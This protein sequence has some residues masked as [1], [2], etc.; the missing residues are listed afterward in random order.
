MIY[1]TPDE[2]RT[3]ALRNI[4]FGIQLVQKQ[5]HLGGLDFNYSYVCG[6]IQMASCLT[7]ISFEE[8]DALKKRLNDVQKAVDKK[9]RNK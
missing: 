8:E 7:L 1:S 5:E 3:G 6:Q 4:E 9:I 2:M